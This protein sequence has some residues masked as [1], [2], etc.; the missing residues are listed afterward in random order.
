[1]LPV[2]ILVAATSNFVVGDVRTFGDWAVGCD[3]GRDCHATS[4]PIEEGTDEPLSDGNVT[5]AIKRSG[6]PHGPISVSFTAT[7]AGPIDEIQQIDAAMKKARW[8]AVD[9][10]RIDI[11]LKTSNDI[12]A[13]DP[14]ASAKLIVAMRGN[15][16]VSL[17]DNRGEPIATVSLRGLDKV[18]EYIDE[19]QFLTDTVAALA[20]RGKKPVNASTVPAMIPRE[21]ISISPKSDVPPVQFNADQ[22]A[23]LRALDPCL[24]YSNNETVQEPSYG[25]L[26]SLNTL[27]ILP[28]SCGGYNPYKMLFVIDEQGGTT[29]ARF[30]PYPGN[31]MKEAPQ[32]PDVWWDEKERLLNSFGRGRVLADCGEIQDYAW[33]K[34]KFLLVQD[35]SMSLC[36]GSTDYITT[37]R[38]NVV[39][40]DNSAPAEIR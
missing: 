17:L 37:Y 5:M 26:D 36:R 7:G 20:R 27:M 10:R 9:D 4:L 35:Q 3:N 29:P 1:V 33:Y 31:D 16:T 22:L 11:R 28:T 6:D 25:R 18:L 32:L 38:V 30:W 39:V 2:M 13:L 21:T 24:P 19:R 12:Y 15:S 8:I 14:K 34:G 40:G 23:K